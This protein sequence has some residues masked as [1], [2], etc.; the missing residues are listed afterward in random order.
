M[1]DRVRRFMERT[2]LAEPV[3]AARAAV[4]RGWAIPGRRRTI[5]AY[6]RD[7]DQPRLHIGCGGNAL[8]GWLNTD[9]DPASDDV[10]YL[11][12]TAPF[13]LDDARF[14]H[15][16]SEHMIEHLDWSGGQAMLR[17]CYRILRP[18]GRI[19]VATPDLAF[20]ID[21]YRADKSEVQ[22][23]YVEWSAKTHLPPDG[24]GA[25]DSFVINHFFRAW[26]HR[27]IYDFDA[28][29]LALEEIGFAEVVRHALGS[30]NAP[31]LRGLERHGDAIPPEFNLLETLVVEA[32]KPG[33][34]TTDG[35]DGPT[36]RNLY[37]TTMRRIVSTC[38]TA[39]LL[40][41]LVPGSGELLE[42]AVHLVREGHSAHAAPEG[43][44][45]DPPTPEHG[46]SGIVHL[47]SCCAS[48]SFLPAQATPQVPALESRRFVLTAD[49]HP[50]AMSP[51]GVYRPPRS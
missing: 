11:D 21:L 17:E 46:C 15:V 23:R 43:D 10:V 26:G 14:V 19:R 42:N 18:G 16:F 50:P 9:L 34:V 40:W 5:A 24:P 3:R 28:L 27:L 22:R 48:S 7:H 12:A 8:S 45:H 30:S 33:R 20:L 4:R 47:C 44:R 35:L 31:A 6:C 39:L 49:A 29:K 1:R 2:G 32:A 13:P 38:I 41:A 36:P 37:S 25:L 51:G